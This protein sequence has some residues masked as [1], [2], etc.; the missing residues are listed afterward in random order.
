MH[1]DDYSHLFNKDIF[2]NVSAVIVAFSG[3]ADSVALLSLI[4]KLNNEGVLKLDKILALHVNHGI[5]GEEA[6]R[7]AEFSREFAAK[8]GVEFKLYEGDVPLMS[9][10]N[11]MSIEEA[12]RDFR[13]R[14]YEDGMAY[15]A[16]LGYEAKVALAHHA[17][18]QAETI[19]FRLA[20]GTGSDGLAGIRETNTKAGIC[21]LRPLLNARKAELV[22]YLNSEGL[23]YVTDSTNN[24]NEYT[25]NYI[26][27]VIIP[28]MATVNSNAVKHIADTANQ[29]AKEQDY[30]NELATNWL[31]DKLKTDRGTYIELSEFDKL[32]EVLKVYVIRGFLRRMNVRL[33]DITREHYDKLI[34]I[35]H[36]ENAITLPDNVIVYIRYG[37]IYIITDNKENAS[38]KMPIS[39]TFD[40]VSR[41]KAEKIGEKNYT[42]VVDYDKIE[43]ALVVRHRE[44]G[45]YI[46]VDNK[47]TKKTLSRFFIDAKIAKHMRDEIT[48]V[49]DGHEIVWVVGYRLNM[50]YYVTKDTTRYLILE[51]EE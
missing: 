22:E 30:M 36:E 42:K 21:Y 5:R 2:N 51:A 25:R 18:D 34:K 15:L 9:K 33:K 23:S 47:G 31:D 26:R 28:E 3:G 40:E 11:A 14:C 37:Q 8:L 12:G 4:V 35:G 45:D 6:L 24:E 32:H 41:E 10:A 27:N 16:R 13:E 38:R 19:I 29:I 20:R 46:I 7:D 50:R 1:K 48:V 44:E 49:A 17:D 39:V 43:S